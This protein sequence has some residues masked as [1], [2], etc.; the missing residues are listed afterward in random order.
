MTTFLSWLF[1]NVVPSVGTLFLGVLLDKLTKIYIASRLERLLWKN[2]NSEALIVVHGGYN[3]LKG[4]KK[5]T[6][7][8]ERTFTIE[9]PVDNVEVIAFC[10]LISNWKS[11]HKKS[12]DFKSDIEMKNEVSCSFLSL[13]GP[14]FNIKS[15]QQVKPNVF[16]LQWPGLRE[17]IS[18]AGKSFNQYHSSE[19]YEFA[20][21]MR[22]TIPPF[23]SY[24]LCAGLGASG[25]KWACQFLADRW[26]EI[27][28]TV[29]WFSWCPFTKT[30]DFLIILKF[31]RSNHLNASICAAFIS[32]KGK[33]KELFSR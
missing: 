4:V 27:H 32:K 20:V 26:K 2:K 6:G 1:Q 30:P 24:I 16:Q 10:S 22:Q 31:R 14:D 29:S 18:V 7:I 19:E 9:N 3:S 8:G 33:I 17:N 23:H 11:I 21:I 25:T 13:G 15:H 12:I 28:S 5:E